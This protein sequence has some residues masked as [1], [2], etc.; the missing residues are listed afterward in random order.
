MVQKIAL[1]NHK[2][3][4]SKTTTTFNLGWMLAEKGK[5]VILADTDPQCNLTGMAL[6]EG[7]EEDEERIEQIY[8]TKS[9]I[10]TGLAPAFESQPKAIEAI[11]CLPIEGRDG[12]F[13]LPGNV[14]LAEYEVTLGIA[15]ELSGSIQTLKNLPGSINYLFERT[16][17]KFDA[18]YIL[19]DMSPSLGSINQNLLMIS[20]FFIVP[21]TADFFSVM[22]IDSLSKVL[23][24]WYRWAKSASD[25][26]ILKEADYPFPDLT[27]RFLGTIVQ[28]YRIKNG[29]ETKAFENWIKRIEET[30]SYKLV[31]SLRRNNMLLPEKAYKQQQIQDTFTLKKIP[32]F[33]SLIALSQKHQTPVFRLSQVEVKLRGQALRQNQQKQQEFE[34]IFSNLADKV[35]ALTSTYAVSH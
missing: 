32:N 34:E 19:I 24:K 16:A 4:V 17:K 8:N 21:T 10:K 1:F 15:Q 5:K 22:A 35:I 14:G 26:P 18:D 25:L 9:N 27:L 23:P 30:V 33:N 31:P 28:N 2:G 29:Q 12:L 6:G 13:L 7:T 11:D 20:D 3:G